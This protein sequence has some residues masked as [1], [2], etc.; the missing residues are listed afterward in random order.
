MKKELYKTHGTIAHVFVSN[1]D[2][3]FALM[4]PNTFNSLK[5]FINEL[6]DAKELAGNPAVAD[7][8][9]NLSNK[10]FNLYTSTLMTYMTGSR[11]S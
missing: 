3:I 1:K 10:G 2:K 8:K 6:L 5:S 11:V 7:V 9:A 4:Q